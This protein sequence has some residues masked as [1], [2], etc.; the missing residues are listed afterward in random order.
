[1]GDHVLLHVSSVSELLSTAE[2]L[3]PHVAAQVSQQRV[4]EAERLPALKAGEQLHAAASGEA[5]FSG[6]AG[7]RPR[8]V[9]ADTLVES[10]LMRQ[11]EGFAAGA[12]A[13]PCHSGVAAHVSLQ[14][15]FPEKNSGANRATEASFCCV[16]LQVVLLGKTFTDVFEEHLRSRNVGTL[17]L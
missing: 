8:G 6:L 15:P 9:S 3:F 10:E 14:L 4:L 7:V 13:E 11:S 5:G 12:A 17:L 1:M 16:T 2:R